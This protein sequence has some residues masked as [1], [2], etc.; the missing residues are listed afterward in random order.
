MGRHELR[1]CDDY[2]IAAITSEP[3]AGGL[4]SRELMEA[5]TV[6]ALADALAVLTAPTEELHT[7]MDTP[8]ARLPTRTPTPLPARPRDGPRAG[9]GTWEP[10]LTYE[11]LEHLLHRMKTTWQM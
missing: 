10:P 9:E 5:P 6:R 8:P 4:H 3:V 1:N 7:L 11:E 2:P